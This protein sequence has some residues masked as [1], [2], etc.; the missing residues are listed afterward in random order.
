LGVL[1]LDLEKVS[2]NRN[3]AYRA[4]LLPAVQVKLF[5]FKIKNY[6]AYQ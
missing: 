2:L 4:I 5:T 3:Y 1:P 6:G